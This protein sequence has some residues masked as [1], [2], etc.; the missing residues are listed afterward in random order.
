[1]KENEEHAAARIEPSF[2]A[3]RVLV[4]IASHGEK[5]RTFLKRVIAAYRAMRCGLELVVNSDAP[6]TFEPGVRVI[7]GRPTRDP[8]SLPFA[9]KRLFAT[10]LERYDLFIYT[11]DDIEVTESNIRAFLR[12][13]TVLEPSEVAGHIRYEVGADGAVSVP[14]AHAQYHWRPESVRLRGEFTVAEFTNEHA[15]MYMLTQA[16]LR[17]VIASGGYL[18][19]SGEGRYGMLESAATDPFTRCGLRK[20]MCI[21]ALDEFLIHHLPN[22]YVGVMGTPLLD[23]RQQIDALTAIQRGMWPVTTYC[24][25]EPKVLQRNWS[26]RYDEKPGVELIRVLPLRPG[27]SVLSVGSGAGEIE[28]E[29]R[30]RRLRITA[31]PLDSVSGYLLR[32]RGFEVVMSTHEECGDALRGRTFDC[33]LIMN[34]LHLLPDWRR[35]LRRLG[36]VVGRNGTLVIAGYNFDYLPH[37]VKRLCRVG[38]FGR[39]RRFEEGGVHTEGVSR[40]SRELVQ[41]GFGIESLAWYDDA[42]PASWARGRRWPPRMLRRNWIMRARRRR[43]V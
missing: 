29:L 18:R 16:Q 27:A 21:S 2:G 10:N 15:G 7:V 9:H 42:P 28:L 1:M 26:K 37:R 22:N 24:E 11:E 39:L 30:R 34:L 33:V 6:R 20:V 25:V 19:D 41:L 14:D 17:R 23:F 32:H 43:E 8:R 12:A 4:A 13:S 36:G 5:N 40:V 3:L 35:V 38:E 31:V